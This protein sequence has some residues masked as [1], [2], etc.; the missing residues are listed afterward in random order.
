MVVKHTPECCP[1]W[2]SFEDGTDRRRTGAPLT[3][4]RHDRGL[5]TKIGYGKGSVYS[6]RITGRKRRQIARLR[7]EHNRARVATKA[8]QNRVC[9]FTE[10]KRVITHLSLPDS[11]REQACTL[12]ESAQSEGLLQGRSI[13]GFAAASIYATCRTRSL[14]R[15]VDEIVTVARADTNELKVAYAALNRELGLPTGPIDPTEYLPRYASKLDLETAVEQRAH[16]Y[17][18]SLREAKLIGG[19]N[20]SGVVAACLH[21]AAGECEE[22]SMI[23]QADAADVADV[24]PSTIR[25][26]VTKID[27]RET[28]S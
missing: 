23:T 5:S 3:R 19:H 2:R 4:S 26:T 13:E 1:E 24:T 27:Q 21:R 17:V 28:Q 12:F 18:A 14:T 6:N 22:W 10:I 8:D 15:T 7:R 11:L 20:P 16:E 25:S 9:G